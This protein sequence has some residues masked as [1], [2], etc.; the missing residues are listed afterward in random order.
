MDQAAVA[1]LT[2]NAYLDSLLH[3]VRSPQTPNPKLKSSTP[4]MYFS[5]L[6]SISSAW[7]NPAG[8]GKQ[9]ERLSGPKAFAAGF[10][11]RTVASVTLLPLTV[12]KTR[13]EAGQNQHGGTLRTLAWIAREEGVHGLCRGLVPTVLRDAPFSGMY[14]VSYTRLKAFLRDEERL[15]A[16]PSQA[17]NF[18]A[19]IVAGALAS[20]M[21]NP[22]DVVRT[23]L[24]LAPEMQKGS[25]TLAVSIAEK[26]GWRAL[27]LRGL[28]PRVYKKS[29]AAAISWTVYEEGVKALAG[30]FP[31]KNG[32]PASTLPAHTM[33]PIEGGGGGGQGADLVDRQV[34]KRLSGRRPEGG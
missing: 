27:W 12:V 26:E 9:E 10:T 17:K 7:S 15:D 30:V 28:G 6:N 19:G 8:S 32:S 11:A 22:F 31:A 2:M 5:L 25:M 34:L 18:G 20:L 16:I 13:F 23:R 14:Y 3:V 1:D 29:L 24:Q 4:G 21:T 33:L